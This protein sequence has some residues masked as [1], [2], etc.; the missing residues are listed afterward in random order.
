MREMG[1]IST[2]GPNR[3][4]GIDSLTDTH[5]GRMRPPPERVQDQDLELSEV[6]PFSLRHGFHIGDIRQGAEPVPEDPKVTVP[7]RQ[8]QNPDSGD[9][10]FPSRLEGLQVELGFGG[11]FVWPDR[12]IENVEGNPERTRSSVSAGP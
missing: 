9:R 1:E 3:T 4:G 10:D 11:P 12:I 6:R 5:V 2:L 8:R 7:E